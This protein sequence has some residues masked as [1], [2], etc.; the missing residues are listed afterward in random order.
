MPQSP[1]DPAS[2]ALFPEMRDRARV[3]FDHALAECGIPQ[4][5]S[6]KLQCRGRHLQS[7]NEIYDLRAFERILVVSIGKAGHSMAEVFANIVDTGLTGIIAAPTA[8]PA[9]LF[10]FR[11]FTGGHPLPNDDSLRAGDAILRLLH[12]LSPETLAV[13]LISGGASAIAEKP[14]SDGITLQDVVETYRALVHSGAPIAEINAI[15]KHL[16]ALKGGRLALAAAP[17]RQLSVLVSDVPEGSLDA[18][19]SGPTMPDTTTVEE[20]YDLA[21]RYQ[22]LDR[23]PPSVR[24]L[25]SGRQLK[26]TPKAGDP[27]FAHS[28]YATVLSNATAVNAAVESA[29]LGGFAVEVDNSCDDWDYQQAADHLLRRL[30]QLRRGASRA[31]LISGGEVTVKVGAASGLGGRNQQFALYCAEKIAGE[32]VTVLSAGTDGI[33]GNSPAAGAIADGSTLERARRRGLD[34]ATALVRFDSFPLFHA[35][36]DAIMTGPTGNNVRDLRI[37][38]AY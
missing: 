24:S 4:A 3:M 5:F 31:C 29:K 15:R 30:R 14:I 2:G 33:D 16:S 11:Y 9:Q 19:A 27:A 38:L 37:L 34:A 1:A 28:H 25:F 20:C 7:G 35:I 8:P 22:L 26:E 23:F 17:A 12:G 21:Q 10:G 18:L 13:F 36:G 6:R 32:N